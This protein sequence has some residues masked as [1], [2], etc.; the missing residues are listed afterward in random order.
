MLTSRRQI[1]PRPSVHAWCL[2][3]GFIV[4]AI[5]GQ[6]GIAAPFVPERNAQCVAFSPDGKLAATGK[7][8]LSNAEFPPRPHPSPRKCGVVHVWDVETGNLLRRMETFGDITRV[9]FSP[10]GRRLAY[11]RLFRSVDG[12]QLNEVRVWDASTGESLKQFDRCYG[13][14]FAP[15]GSTLAILS[16]RRCTVFS[17]ASWN[18]LNEIEALAKSLAVRFSHDGKVITG[19][20]P[21][22]DR[23][24]LRACL[25]DTGELAVESIGLKKPFYSL[26]FSPDDRWIATGHEKGAVLLWDTETYRISAHFRTGGQG[27]QSPF[28]APNG[29]M[30]ASGDQSNGD[31]VFWDVASGKE[32]R[33]YTFQ[34]GEF[35]TYIRREPSELIRPELD[36]VRFVFAPSGDAFLAGCYGGIIRTLTDGREL[37]RFTE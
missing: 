3:Y 24:T 4:L 32:Q 5:S 6:A 9:A 21:S 14:D 1:A 37:K 36:P 8:G 18:K 13:F 35:R 33:R 10:D 26:S 27:I 22:G 23:F 11:S 16:R 34:R 17:T 25:T 2:L 20:V 30:L 15:D 31:V 7:S 19:I 28:F 29:A 12:V